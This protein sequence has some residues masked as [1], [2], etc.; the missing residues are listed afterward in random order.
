MKNLSFPS[1]N[2]ENSLRY[3]LYITAKC[4][5]VEIRDGVETKHAFF[6]IKSRFLTSVGMRNLP[7]IPKTLLV[8]D[9]I[10]N[11]TGNASFHAVRSLSA[12]RI[13]IRIK[14]IC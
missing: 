11:D 9:C 14:K 8:T 6:S 4:S 1:V 12:A 13:F 3:L 7:L 2:L 10:P 5:N